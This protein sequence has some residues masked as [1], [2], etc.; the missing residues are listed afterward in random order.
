MSPKSTKRNAPAFIDGASGTTPPPKSDGPGGL[1]PPNSAT[2]Q[3]SEPTISPEEA[4]KLR[5]ELNAL[6]QKDRQRTAAEQ[7]RILAQH[8]ERPSGWSEFGASQKLIKLDGHEDLGKILEVATQKQLLVRDAIEQTLASDQP[9]ASKVEALAKATP[10]AFSVLAE[11]FGQLEA[12]ADKLVGLI[13]AADALASGSLGLFND[14]GRATEVSSLQGL[15]TKPAQVTGQ[16]F[17]DAR[18]LR[19]AFGAL[20]R[21]EQVTELLRAQR[22]SDT[23]LLRAVLGAHEIQ[24]LVDP[25]R[26]PQLVRGALDATYPGIRAAIA[27]R[28]SVLLASFRASWAQASL[29]A[30]GLSAA[31]ADGRLPE[32]DR[33]QLQGLERRVGEQIGRLQEIE[34]DWRS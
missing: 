14:A 33:E 16:A 25:E 30:A 20:D 2:D 12:A 34:N 22:N 6:K 23:R 26:R 17:D 29:L 8:I 9:R 11:P 15:T 13:E 28:A 4:Q 10:D 32:G 31:R 5:T 19:I 1:R 3:I 7:A 24:R 18:E 27:G 21:G